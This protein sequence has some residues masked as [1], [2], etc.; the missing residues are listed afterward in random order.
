[1]LNTIINPNII[2]NTARGAA[3]EYL[4]RYGIGERE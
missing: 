1:M 4:W 3:E 2:R